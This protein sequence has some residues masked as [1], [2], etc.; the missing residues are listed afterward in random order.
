MSVKDGSNI[1]N[2]GNIE[3][4]LE[5]ATVPEESFVGDDTE[6]WTTTPYPKGFL[7]LCYFHLSIMF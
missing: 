6:N 4:L 2:P 3:K 1:K 5:D 7:I